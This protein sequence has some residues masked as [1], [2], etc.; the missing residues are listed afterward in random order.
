MIRPR[1]VIT[2]KKR[3]VTMS[4]K[5]QFNTITCE[6]IISVFVYIRILNT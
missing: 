3:K 6:D 1:K 5:Q 2:A 4:G